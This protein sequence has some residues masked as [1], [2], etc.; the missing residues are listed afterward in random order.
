MF[1]LELVVEA[2]RLEAVV[3]KGLSASIVVEDPQIVNL[4]S[5]SGH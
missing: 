5:V 2:R 3:F 1:F 4:F